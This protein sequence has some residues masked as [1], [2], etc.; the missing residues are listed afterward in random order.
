MGYVEVLKARM[1][2]RVVSDGNYF[3]GYNLHI[4]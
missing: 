4:K 3:N 1:A 2:R